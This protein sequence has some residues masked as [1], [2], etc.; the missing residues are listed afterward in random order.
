ML[1]VV[2]A[3]AFIE[4]IAGQPYR[5]LFAIALTTGMRPSEYVGLTWKDLDLDRGTVSV[6]HTLEWRRGVGS[7]PKQR[8]HEAAG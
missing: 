1:S 7:S 5:D 4:A 8:G 3:R 2:Q 6:S